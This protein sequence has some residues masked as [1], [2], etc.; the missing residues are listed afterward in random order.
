MSRAMA[1]RLS[2]LDAR[3]RLRMVNVSRKRVTLR[4]AVARG[5][6]F[7]HARTLRLLREQALPK[8]DALAAA[9]L[10]AVQ[11]AKRTWEIVPL[12]HPLPLEGVDVSFA[13]QDEVPGVAVEVRVTARARTGVEME[14]LVAVTAAGLALYDM[15]KAVDRDMVLGEVAVWEKR[16]GR[17]GRYRRGP[18]P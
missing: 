2:H 4:T 3:G 16:G 5:K 14:A 8:G 9:H 6:L 10:A 17:T 13:L 15:C 7:M 12:A 1:P 11:A 18:R